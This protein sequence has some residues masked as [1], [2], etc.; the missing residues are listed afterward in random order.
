MGMSRR[1]MA[2]ANERND[3]HAA[4]PAP[5]MQEAEPAHAEPAEALAD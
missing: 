2:A 5:A 1:S 4:S 3:G